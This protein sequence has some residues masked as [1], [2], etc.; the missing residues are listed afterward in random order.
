MKK[1]LKI[2]VIMIMSFISI[3]YVK[4]EETGE[5]ITTINTVVIG[6]NQSEYD[7]LKNNGNSYYC[8]KNNETVNNCNYEETTQELINYY[9]ENVKSEYPYYIIVGSWF[10]QYEK[11]STSLLY[12]EDNKNS[13]NYNGYPYI[14]YKDSNGRI[15][16]TSGSIRN[17]TGG[18]GAIFGGAQNENIL[19]KEYM[20]FDSNFDIISER[21]Y[22][23]ANFYN[24]NSN[25]KINIGDKFP[26]I[27]DLI[28]YNSWSDYEN[29]YL[30]GYTEVNLDNYEYVLLSLKNYN[31][32]KAF[33]TNWN[34][35]NL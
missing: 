35:T 30:E 21:D 22:E 20:Y 2:L 29:N 19:Y 18:A 4:A 23:I 5:G 25:L 1:G 3:D 26:K 10:S 11:I 32:T 17:T 7:F 34:Y 15:E 28:Q 14:W 24:D 33:S 6:N 27:K 8:I 12:Y 13:F 16:R 31:Q 9:N